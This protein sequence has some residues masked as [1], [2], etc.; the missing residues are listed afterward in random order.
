MPIF[1][2]TKVSGCLSAMSRTTLIHCD[3]SKRLLHSVSQYHLNIISR[4]RDIIHLVP[5]DP[6]LNK[7]REAKVSLII[8]IY[9][10]FTAFLT[11]LSDDISLSSIPLV[12]NT[13]TKIG[14]R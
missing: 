10:G 12:S 8:S 7:F 5:S 3:F 2:K 1:L 9:L 6:S 4:S 14:M 11:G 13:E